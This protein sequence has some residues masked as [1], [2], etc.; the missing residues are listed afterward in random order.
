MPTPT[1]TI[2]ALPPAASATGTQHIIVQE[3]GVTKK[4][5]IDQIV[6]YIEGAGSVDDVVWV[7]T[8]APAETD[9]ELWFDTD[10][11]AGSGSSL[12][13][14]TVDTGDPYRIIMF[15]NGDVRAIPVGVVEPGTPSSLAR[16]IRINAV[17]LTWVAGTGAATYAVYRD[18][19]AYATASTNS[20]RDTSV[21]VGETYTYAVQSINAYG[22]R[23]A[24]TS[25]V[26]AFIDPA[27][28]V[29][30]T[31]EVRAWPTTV[32]A[33]NRAVIRVNAIDADAQFLALV[34]GV[35]VG[36]LVSTADPSTWILEP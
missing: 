25:T 11:P 28:N 22:L 5:T 9:V 32:A 23:S 30:P 15:S 35:D 34:L 20:Y 7:G 3:S 4:L 33:G 10:A 13:D 26:T 8:D 12:S 21:T 2:D 6:T 18:G 29:A 17:R 19:V 31:V 1:T 14:S 27:L 24:V 36:S 16:T